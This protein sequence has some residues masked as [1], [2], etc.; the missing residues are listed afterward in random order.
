MP[1]V[2]YALLAYLGGLLAGFSG[3][4]FVGLTAILAAV[5]V[6]ARQRKVATVAFAAL[7]TGG[8]AVAS[9]VRQ[10]ETRCID[11]AA[12]AAAVELIADDTLAAGLFAHGQLTACRSSVGMMVAEGNAS[13]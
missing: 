5:V 6:G 13:A 2:A 7:A 3:S 1:L 10:D 9:A 12:H 8:V 11:T 4:F